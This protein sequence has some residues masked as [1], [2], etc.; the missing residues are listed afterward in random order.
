MR[1]EKPSRTT[2]ARRTAA[3]GIGKLAGVMACGVCGCRMSKTRRTKGRN[4]EGYYYYYFCPT[5]VNKGQDACP[6]VRGFRA[7]HVEAQVWE[8]VRSLMLNPEH[9]LEDIERM[10]EE[11]RTSAVRGD[12]E[13]EASHW[14]D[15]LAEAD[16]ER[17][18]FLRLAARG[19]ITDAELDEE[20]GELAELRNTAE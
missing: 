12:P 1:P 2:Y 20:L 8:L 11:E 13:H 18:G 15:K 16:N 10:I 9:L 4:Y 6:Q 7:E 3:T 17:R 19:S 14:L 5:R